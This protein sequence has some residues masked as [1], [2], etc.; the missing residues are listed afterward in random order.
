MSQ[1]QTI[2]P[3]FR[4]NPE[5]VVEYR[6]I[7]K[8]AVVALILGLAS[9]AAFAHPVLWCIP[10]AAVVV[11]IFAVR[12]TSQPEYAGRW[13]AV[14]GLVLALVCGG[15]A[16]SL[17]LVEKM[18]VKKQARTF[19]DA[20]VELLAEKKLTMA[21]EWTMSRRYRRPSDMS[22]MEYYGQNDEAA[23]DLT[24]FKKRDELRAI[25]KL[26][27]DVRVTFL[28][29]GSVQ[30]SPFTHRCSSTYRFE[31]AAGEKVDLV[32]E[33]N[34]TDDIESTSLVKD[35]RWHVRLFRMAESEDASSL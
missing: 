23:G 28:S 34:R 16:S 20:W 30:R 32:V 2:E 35:A 6:S 33:A 18:V 21:Y 1:E 4:S 17:K 3:A 5:E 9:F 24:T 15:A 25:Q 8:L 13:A 29:T 27:P 31:N 10:V 12:I 19:S 14:C 26:G 22:I 11:S 7:S